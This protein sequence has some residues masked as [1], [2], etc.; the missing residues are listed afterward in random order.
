MST[1]R[2]LWE[3]I[4]PGLL[5]AGTAVGVS[6]LVQATRAGAGYGLALLWIVIAAN[7]L[8]YPAYEAG[9]RY[10]VATG[11]SLL[12]GY[13]KRGIWAIYLFIALTLSTMCTVIAA[14]AFVSAGMA[15]A[16]ITDAIPIWGWSA[17]LLGIAVGLLA[18]GSFSWLQRFMTA[19]MLLLTASTILS[20]LFALPATDFS[21]L[22]LTPG[23]PPLE[24]P[25]LLFVAG[26]V[27]WMPSALDTAVWYSMWS[28]E[29]ARLD[30]RVLT[31]EGSRLDFNIGYLGTAILAVLFVFLGA[32]I[33]NGRVQEMPSSAAAFAAT[34]VNAYVTALG[35]WS[36]PII[37][38]AAFSTM[39]STTIAVA[40]GFPRAL[41][42]SVRILWDGDSSS[43]QRTWVYWLALLGSVGVAQMICMFFVGNLMTLVDLATGLTG[44]TAP[45]FA[46]LNFATVRG[47]EVP[48]HL[49]P[50]RSYTAFHLVGIL[51]LWVIVDRSVQWGRA[52]RV[53]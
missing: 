43:G 4:G 28:L 1:D 15:A 3:S 53:P 35:G 40:D 9:A 6:H 8:K 50:S 23:F 19:M 36:R 34:L 10:A 29:K 47:E 13:K 44:L 14:V 16:L 38:V 33:L 12:S 22:S 21:E 30:E 51:F 24:R 39:L 17:I 25:Q 32:S 27:G 11:T 37:L 45:I 7:L 46:M 52:K 2:S 5:W 18:I 20:V 48:V 26:L 42:G 49:R 31:T 41:E